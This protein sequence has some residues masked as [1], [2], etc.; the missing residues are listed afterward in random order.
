MDSLMQDAMG[1]VMNNLTGG[2]ELG[3]DVSGLKISATVKDG[4]ITGTTIKGDMTMELDGEKVTMS[5]DIKSV[6]KAT[7]DSVK[8]NIP[9]DLS[10]YVPF[11]EYI[12][13]LLGENK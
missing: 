6:V 8:L 4:K 13:D 5:M 11:N 12:K 10:G 2:M 1:G 3:L 9:T 7:G